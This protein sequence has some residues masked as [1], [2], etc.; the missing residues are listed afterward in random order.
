MKVKHLMVF[1]VGIMG[2]IPINKS[3]PIADFDTITIKDD[4]FDFI[5]ISVVKYSLGLSFV[6]FYLDLKDE[7]TALIKK[8]ET[9]EFIDYY[10][11]IHFNFFA[12]KAN[13]LTMHQCENGFDKLIYDNMDIVKNS[14]FRLIDLLLNQM[15]I[16]KGKDDL[17]CVFDFYID[18][19]PPYFTRANIDNVGNDYILFPSRNTFL[20]RDNL[21]NDDSENIIHSDKFKISNVDMFFLKVYPSIL[22]DKWDNY[23]SENIYNIEGHSSLSIIYLIDK[24][25][26]TVSEMVNEMKIYNKKSSLDSEYERLFLILKNLQMLDV[27]LRKL[28]K[29]FRYNSPE[30]YIKHGS[31][32]IEH[33]INRVKEMNL[34]IKDNFSLAENKVQ[35]KNIKFNKFYSKIVFALVLIQIF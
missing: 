25:V 9:P 24:K 5:N 18:Q 8:I 3:N 17:F 4:Y 12:K 33:L 11:F 16:V 22:D 20:A 28:K 21:S 10:Q 32:L 35:V 15:K 30:K 14:S 7:T 26:N 29:E 13:G 27:W 6:T 2:F 1:Q 23:Q 34:I 31:L 19:F